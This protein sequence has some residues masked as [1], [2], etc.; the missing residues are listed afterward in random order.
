MRDSILLYKS[1]CDALRCLPPDHFKAAVIAI[2]DYGMEDKE[3]EGD[4]IA[5]A[6]V[7][8]A[9]PVIDKNNR[10]YENGKHGGRNRN[11][12]DTDRK[13]NDNRDVTDE[14]PMRNPKEKGERLKEKGEKG[15][16]KGETVN[17]SILSDGSAL[18]QYKEI[19]DYLNIKA[20]TQYKYAS[21]DTRSHI[22]ARMDQGFTFEDFCTVI[23]KK[24]AEWKGTEYEK[25]LRPSTLFGTKFESYLNQHTRSNDRYAVVDEWYRRYGNDA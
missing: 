19:I 22:K 3:P 2:W 1:Q 4:P 15:K 13:P 9:K 14:E 16:E 11:R 7:G 17:D 8:M 24:V 23:D 18:Y 20:D 10:N 12:S 6:M 5:I 25:F 21:K